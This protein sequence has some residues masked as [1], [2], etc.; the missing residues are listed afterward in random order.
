MTA[1]IGDATRSSGKSVYFVDIVPGK[2][3]FLNVGLN[4]N[5]IPAGAILN[6]FINLNPTASSGEYPLAFSNPAGVDACG[7]DTATTTSDGATTVEGSAGS[8]LDPAG[9]LNAGSFL[10]VPWR[11]VK[12]LP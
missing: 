7:Q 9:A 5:L 4:Q 8:R 11:R 3:R 1:T 12:S 10:P 2:R 6:L